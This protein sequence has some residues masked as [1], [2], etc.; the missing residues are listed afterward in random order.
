MSDN[1]TASTILPEVIKMSDKKLLHVLRPSQQLTT[2]FRD[3]TG[4]VLTNLRAMRL[5]PDGGNP[6]AL[7]HVTFVNEVGVSLYIARSYSYGGDMQAFLSKESVAWQAY[8]SPLNSFN[9]SYVRSQHYTTQ[10][11]LGFI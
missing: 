9:Q 6:Y 8:F 2:R 4:Q 7:V 11:P 1:P 10:F 3:A 5:T